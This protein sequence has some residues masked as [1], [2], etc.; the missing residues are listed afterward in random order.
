MQRSNP[1]SGRTSDCGAK[2][3]PMRTVIL[4]MPS[5]PAPEAAV[6]PDLATTPDSAANKPPPVGQTLA[7]SPPGHL[8]GA[9]SPVP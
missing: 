1:R 4:R 2:T 7:G 6:P 3:R 5:V 9:P 8:R